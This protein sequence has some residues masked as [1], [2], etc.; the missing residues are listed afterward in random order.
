VQD[1]E[2]HHN[3]EALTELAHVQRVH[4]SV[5]DTRRDQPGD[6]AEAVAALKR[7]TK[8]GTHPPH[9]LLVVDRDNAPRTADLREETVK[10]VKRAHVEHATAR[11]PIR[12]K[13]PKGGSR[14]RGRSPA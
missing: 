2:T 8:A 9:V 13:H 3:V 6:R 10:A 14:G 12:A 5:L 7:H 1:A 4:A 11:K